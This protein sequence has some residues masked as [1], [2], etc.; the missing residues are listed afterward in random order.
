MH[1]YMLESVVWCMR[2]GGM[3][4]VWDTVVCVVYEAGWNRVRLHLHSLNLSSFSP[5]PLLAKQLNTLP[6]PYLSSSER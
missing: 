6:Q 3:C 5:P 2:H 1:G 4:G